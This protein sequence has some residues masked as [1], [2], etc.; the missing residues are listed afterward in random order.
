MHEQGPAL[1]GLVVSGQPAVTAHHS[2][3][4]PGA[5]RLPGLQK[6]GASRVKPLSRRRERG[7]G[8]GKQATSPHTTTQWPNFDHPPQTL[9]PQGV[10]TLIHTILPHS[11]HRLWRTAPPS[12][13]VARVSEAHPGNDRSGIHD[14]LQRSEPNTIGA[15]LRPAPGC[16]S[17]YPGYRTTAHR[18]M[19][20]S[21]ASGRG[22]G[23][24]AT[25][26]RQSTSKPNGQLL[27]TLRKPLQ[28]NADAGLS[29]R[30]SRH[31][32]HCLWRTAQPRSHVARVSEAH[33]GNDRSGKPIGLHH[34]EPNTI[35]A[36]LR[37]APGCAS[38][39]PGYG[40][41]APPGLSPSPASGRGVGVRATK[42][43]QST[44]QP[45]G[46]LLTTPRKPLQAN[47]RA[48]LSTRFARHSPHNLWRSAQRLCSPGKRTRTREMIEAEHAMISSTAKQT[49]P[50]RHVP[51]PGCASLTRATKAHKQQGPPLA[52]LVAFT[53][54]A[55]AYSGLPPSF[56]VTC[57][58]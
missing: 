19:S 13:H 28:P 15:T 30:F 1:R 23:V 36:S 56:Q 42:Q 58:K 24:R 9:A 34:S 57:T 51:V 38:A 40:I 4:P 43:R 22:V 47:T 48:G 39:Y 3:L 32:P 12:S 29:T 7:W 11:P 14:D 2:V 17:A 31:S 37:P 33:P 46:Q 26:Q 50:K 53:P 52:G 16:A 55:R 6:Y 49:Q 41:A 18:D 10:R 8:E 21:P 20:P 25:T 45:N 54:A 35:G 44:S 27:T 5:L